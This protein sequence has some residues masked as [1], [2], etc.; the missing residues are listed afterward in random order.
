MC[1]VHT[2]SV[3]PTQ[4][5]CTLLVYTV[6][7]DQMQELIGC[8][9]A[10]SPI[11]LLHCLL[12]KC[13]QTLSSAWKRL[14]RAADSLGLP[15][16]HPATAALSPNVPSCWMNS[17]TV[18]RQQKNEGARLLVAFSFAAGVP[19]ST[20]VVF[21]RYVHVTSVHRSILGLARM[22]HKCEGCGYCP[23]SFRRRAF[24]TGVH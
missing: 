14:V 3:G 22:I 15:A 11:D 16:C 19:V 21:L 1:F 17:S 12:T 20:P 8:N 6:R 23:S 10:T 2:E 13:T 18:P 9:C 5:E 7:P 24:V 4:T